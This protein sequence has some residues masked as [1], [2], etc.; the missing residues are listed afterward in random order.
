M[1]SEYESKGFNI[2]K[3][4]TDKQVEAIRIAREKT[5]SNAWQLLQNAVHLFETKQYALSCFSA[6]TAIEESGKL[7]V[8]QIIQGDS[9]KILYEGIRVPPEPNISA[10]QRFLRNHVEKAIQAAAMSLY[11]NEGADRRHGINSESGMHR[12]SGVIL[13]ARSGKWMEVR[14]ACLYTDL[15]LIDDVALAPKDVITPEHAYY[16]ICMAFE[17]VAE[18]SSSGF[19]NSF[20]SGDSETISF[21]QEFVTDLE[22]LI[23]KRPSKDAIKQLL[24]NASKKYPVADAAKTIG[25]SMQ[26]WKERLND[27]GKFMER[28]GNTVDIDKLEFLCNP[29]PLRGEA[30]KR[31]MRS[32]SG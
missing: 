8:L 23:E 6:M 25:K 5:L 26:F 11:I 14:N 24:E 16:F 3:T 30:E 10:L 4:L 15:N 9:M 29:E 22:R 17:V 21:W 27:L 18:Q 28:W 31:E 1:P 19:G 20:E 32:N 7:F 12:T 2:M 13:L